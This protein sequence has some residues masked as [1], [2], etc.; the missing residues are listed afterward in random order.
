MWHSS[1]M[2]ILYF[3]EAGLNCTD[4]MI[5]LTSSTL[6]CDAASSSVTS[7]EWPAAISRQLTHSPHGSTPFGDWQFSALANMRERVVF[8]M[9]RE[10]MNRYAFATRPAS[11]AWRS[12]RTT[13]SCPTTSS[14]V[15]G[16]YFRGSA[17]WGASD[18]FILGRL[19]S[20][21]QTIFASFWARPTYVAGVS[22]RSRALSSLGR[23]SAETNSR[24]MS[25][26][27][28]RPRV[29]SFSLSYG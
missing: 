17:M 11:I 5:G 8:P 23:G 7:S 19:A 21:R 27:T 25:A 4:S 24:M 13:C 16:R 9:P 29:S 15:M 18:I 22:L 1:I 26:V 3:E 28:R 20:L 10:P 2:Y 14:N 6:L 12:V